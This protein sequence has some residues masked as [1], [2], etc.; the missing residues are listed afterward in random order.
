MTELILKL[1]GDET[2]TAHVTFVLPEI[3][4]FGKLDGFVAVTGATETV[5]IVGVLSDRV[6]TVCVA[7]AVFPFVSVTVIVRV[8]GA[9]LRGS[10]VSA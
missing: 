2:A 5:P 1:N 9:A 8:T 6:L 10:A 7:V 4:T 3:Y